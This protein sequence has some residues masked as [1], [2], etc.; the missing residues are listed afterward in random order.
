MHRDLNEAAA[1]DRF[2]K[3]ILVT[4]VLLLGVIACRRDRDQ[5]VAR[6][7][8]DEE[9][10]ITAFTAI[11]KK[12]YLDLSDELNATTTSVNGRLHSLTPV[13]L[14]TA[15]VAVLIVPKGTAMKTRNAL[16]GQGK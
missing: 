12:T 1:P 4:M 7:A 9:Y 5:I 3:A 10:L 15:Y 6:A 8:A 13:G 11:D 2:T 16:N 14:G